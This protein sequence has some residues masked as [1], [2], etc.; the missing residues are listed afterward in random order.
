[1]THSLKG[2]W[3]QAFAFANGSTCTAT[4]R[5]A[6]ERQHEHAGRQ[7]ALRQPTSEAAAATPTTT[8]S[9]ASS[10]SAAAS[11][12][13]RLQPQT[14]HPPHATPRTTNTQLAAGAAGAAGAT[15]P[16]IVRIEEERVVIE[17]DEPSHPGY[18]ARASIARLGW[19]GDADEG[20]PQPKPQQ[21]PQPQQQPK[22]QPQQQPQQP[23]PQSRQSQ[24][25]ERGERRLDEEV[26]YGN[27]KLAHEGQQ[28]QHQHQRQDGVNVPRRQGRF[29]TGGV[30]MA[31]GRPP[32]AASSAAAVGTQSA[33][34]NARRRPRTSDVM[35]RNLS[36]RS[37][38]DATAA[39]HHASAGVRRTLEHP[40]SLSA[41]RPGGG[42]IGFLTPTRSM[43]P[44]FGASPEPGAVG[45][46]RLNQVDP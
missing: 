40:L 42:V 14:T 27:R 12:A 17:L 37:I 35:I 10:S 2:A 13:A 26:A 9:S 18:E 43:S 15:A 45:R 39:H 4:P 44:A 36:S 20:Q 8:T 28:H 25:H 16:S 21:Q 32:Q 46:C 38:S 30:A 29:S 41:R 33:E 22:P 3:F 11:A 34:E 31:S 7:R 5:L 6:L 19:G 23:Q 1:V 24:Q